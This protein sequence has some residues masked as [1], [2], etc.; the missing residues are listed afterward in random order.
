MMTKSDIIGLAVAAILLCGCA[1]VATVAKPAP[2]IGTLSPDT[3][4]AAETAFSGVDGEA[5]AAPGW[6]VGACQRRLNQRDALVWTT[7]FAG[8]LGGAGG[9]GT[10]IPE[11][12]DRDTRLGLGIS[13]A[14]LAAIS[15]STALIAR[16]KSNEFER[17]CNQWA[18]E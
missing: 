9:L 6:T 8:A 1:G 3:Y 17:Y 18:N 2:M 14:V 16:S 5:D 7:A 12:A 11:D 13:T 15:T 10:A 4:N